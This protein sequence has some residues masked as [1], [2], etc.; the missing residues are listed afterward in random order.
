LERFF[1]GH[2]GFEGFHV[3][4]DFGVDDLGVDLG[5]FDGGMAKHFG[6]GFDGDSIG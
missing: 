2:F 5:G 6:N 4:G 3:V 1:D